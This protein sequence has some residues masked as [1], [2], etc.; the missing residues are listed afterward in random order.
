MSYTA[1]TFGNTMSHLR[2]QSIQPFNKSIH[3]RTKAAKGEDRTFFKGAT[4]FLQV[5]SARGVRNSLG[6]QDEILKKILDDS[7]VQKSLKKTMEKS[8]EDDMV[9]SGYMVIKP[10]GTKVRKIINVDSKFLRGSRASGAKNSPLGLH[11]SESVQKSNFMAGQMPTSA[12]MF[13]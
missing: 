9:N 2:P 4:E 3:A 13:P 8:K 10:N 7:A 6:E 11:L 12:Q 1:R 5:Q